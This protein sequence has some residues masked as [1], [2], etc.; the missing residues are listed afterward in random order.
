MAIAFL[1]YLHAYVLRHRREESRVRNIRLVS[2]NRL[3]ADKTYSSM[4]SMR[5]VAAGEDL[6]KEGDGHQSRSRT[7]SDLELDVYQPSAL[8]SYEAE[9]VN[10]YLRIGSIA[11]SAGSMIHDGFKIASVFESGATIHCYGAL[12]ILVA[13]T[14]LLFTFFQT[15]FLFKSHK[16]SKIVSFIKTYPCL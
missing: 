8:V 10:F 16:V 11:F 6:P 5:D 4:H 9:G 14:H 3:D 2:N 7:P 1:V 12:Y 15:F 13:V